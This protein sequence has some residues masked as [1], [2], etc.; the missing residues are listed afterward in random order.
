MAFSGAP[1]LCGNLATLSTDR[2]VV[3][4]PQSV[5]AFP[6]L[7]TTHIDEVVSGQQLS[8]QT[9]GLFVVAGALLSSERL[10]QPLSERS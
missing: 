3:A 5:G 7:L 4:R 10:S 1:I 8:L 2:V 6:V 9:T